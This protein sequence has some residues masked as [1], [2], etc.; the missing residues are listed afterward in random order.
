MFVMVGVTACQAD[1]QI[2]IETPSGK[3]EAFSIDLARTP[4]EQQQGL[5]FVESM[6]DDYGMLFI[7]S[8]PRNAL[9]WMKNTLIPLDMLFFDENNMLI[10]IEHSATPHDLRPRGP[11]VRVCSILELNGGTAKKLEISTGSKLLSDYTQE[12]LQSSIK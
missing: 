9:F 4:K 2:I 1:K 3:R 11:K 10:H 5:M 12:C 7:Y 8:A 6:A